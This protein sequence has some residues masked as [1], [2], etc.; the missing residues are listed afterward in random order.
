MKWLIKSHTVCART[1][2]DFL[3]VSFAKFLYTCVERK[4]L[5]FDYHY[6]LT[7]LIKEI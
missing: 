2:G 6:N 7:H 5:S 3:R 4:E 1:N